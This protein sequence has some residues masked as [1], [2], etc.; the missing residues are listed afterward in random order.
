MTKA[1]LTGIERQLVLDYLLD[2]N[3]PVTITPLQKDSPQSDTMRAKAV[4]KES[5]GIFPVALRA[6]QLT[7]LDQGIILLKNAPKNVQLFDGKEVCVQFYFNKL[8]LYF[9][10]TMK[11]LKNTLALV[12]PEAIH[13][14]HDI[15]NTSKKIVNAVLYYETGRSTS[16]HIACTVSDAF[17]L[18]RQPKWS[19][20]AEHE[21]EQ[22]KAYLESAVAHGKA[23]GTQLG[24]GLY[25]IPVCRFLVHQKDAMGEIQDRKEPP[26][27]LYL[28]HERIVFGCEKN[29][30][31]FQHG[32]E[33]ALKMGFPLENSPVK[34][35]TIYVTCLLE[36]QYESTDDKR[37]CSVL[38][39]TLLEKEDERFLYEMQ[40]K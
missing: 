22:A 27:I 9:N 26:C 21:Q 5:S 32:A 34:E 30:L 14:I 2:G 37:V 20:I 15:E 3:T 28:N 18:F 29:A 7:V 19:D 4:P 13:R 33:Y 17:P 24:N 40:K 31:P 25:L 6:E 8:G 10:T 38:R 35:R 36:T 12:I 16:L 11:R 1:A 23:T 39:Y